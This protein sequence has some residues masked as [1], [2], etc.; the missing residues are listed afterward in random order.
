MYIPSQFEENRLEVLHGLIAANPLGTLVTL[1]S[2]GLNANHIPFEI[3]SSAGEFGTL[4]AHVA[5]NN[6][7]WH[8]RRDD[9]EPMVVFQGPHAYISPSWYPTK[10]EHGKVVPTYNYA[11]V[12]AYG[13]LRIIEDPAW[14]HDFLARL[15]ARE[16]RH[17]GSDWKIGDAPAD[18]IEKMLSAI[19]GIEIPISRIV[20]K[21]KV[22]QNQPETNRAGVVAGLQKIGGDESLAMAQLVQ[23]R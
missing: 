16:E 9:A 1:A 4:R 7:V 12:H 17:A 18:Y 15:T 13:P 23:S 5:R 2:D 22:S 3:D 14:L 8:D 20:G 6:P 21:W 10:L 11:V 19:V